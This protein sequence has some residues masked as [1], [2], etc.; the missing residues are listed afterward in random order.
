[1][2]KLLALALLLTPTLAHAA[3]VKALFG[4]QRFSPQ[5]NHRVT[6]PLVQLQTQ[7]GAT[8]S[9]QQGAQFKIS[10]DGTITLASGNL[11]IGPVA[12]TPIN[13]AL[14]QGNVTIAPNT[15]LTI[16]ANATKSTGRIYHGEVTAEGTTFSQGQGF[17][18]TPSGARQ[19]FTP[20]AAQAPTIHAAEATTYP[21]IAYTQNQST[22]PAPQPEEE[23][24]EEPATQP[25]PPAEEP[26]TPPDTTPQPQ[27]DDTPTPPVTPQPEDNTPPVTPPETTTEPSTPPEP[28][29]PVTILPPVAVPVG[30][31][32]ASFSEELT[33]IPMPDN[34][35][36]TPSTFR[37]NRYTNN[38]HELLQTETA[39]LGVNP[40]RLNIGTALQA[41]TFSIGP[42]AGLGRWVGGE[43][44]RTAG[45]QSSLINNTFA[46]PEADETTTLIPNSLHYV[47]GEKATNVP[48]SG[49]VT[50]SLAA[51]TQPTYTGTSQAL[52]AGSFTGNLSIDFET[53]VNS[54][55]GV[56][57]FNGTVTMPQTIQTETGQTTTNVNYNISTVTGG[58]PLSSNTFSNASP[59]TV[60][61]P[62]GA[63]ACP[64]G[65]TGTVNA[66]GFGN[67]MSTVGT[68]YNINPT[69]PVGINGAALFTSTP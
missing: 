47:W 19:T 28:E 67:G 5:Q 8:L 63:L 59:L 68:L 62:T 48:T 42:T 34:I 26:T 38:Q 57:H 54:I 9:F 4:T 36:G 31:L 21:L 41:D 45:R 33:G 12:N 43:L 20:A 1:M 69:G 55:V 46:V 32:M 17:L 40:I 58:V 35:H 18:I 61:A 24:E 13:L 49:R 60:T 39:T 23:Q 56:Y 3:P 52:G 7:G 14:P 44:L 66:A 15:A 27:D 29:P 16:T 50:Y 25:Q 6:G 11:R 37:L 64:S 30:N 65:C 22:P 51:A 53:P 2:K 10:E